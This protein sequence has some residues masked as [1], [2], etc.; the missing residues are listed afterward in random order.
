[1]SGVAMEKFFGALDAGGWKRKSVGGN[2]FMAICPAHPDEKPSLSFMEGRDGVMLYCHA[3]CHT[4]DVVAAMSL[5]MSD[6]F[7]DPRGASY[8]YTLNG[9]PVRRV[10]RTPDKVFSQ[11]VIDKTLVTLFATVPLDDLP[12]EV[13]IVEGEKDVLTLSTIGVTAVSAPSGAANW[14]LC[15]YTPLM[16]C[17]KIV[18]VADRD[19][20]G[21]KRAMGLRRLLRVITAAEVSVLISAEGKDATDHVVSGH[22]IG[23]FLP[24]DLPDDDD[25]AVDEALE[26]DIAAQRRV[27][28]VRAEAIRRDEREA[29]EHLRKPLAAKLLADIL[30]MDT[31]YHWQIPGLLEAQDRLV[32]TGS[33]GGGKSMLIRQIG[34]CAAG[35]M[36]PFSHW[37]EEFE[38]LRVLFVDAENTERQ[39]G[40]QSSYMVGRIEKMMNRELRRNVSVSAQGRLDLSV[41]SNLD[42]VH[43]LCD[44]EKPDILAIGPL[45]KLVPK[46]ITTD[47]EAAPLITALDSFRDRGLTLLMEAHA[48]HSR[49]DMRPRGS[50]AL[51]G[52]PEVGFGLKPVTDGD[53]RVMNVVRWRGD[54]DE[55]DWPGRLSRGSRDFGQLPWV[56]TNIDD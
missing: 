24:A 55:R 28:Y 42:E 46:E 40:R 14:H 52:W 32:I 44:Q 35:G 33:E 15:D 51:L 41:K 50:S 8:E 23:E 36:H 4:E 19:E 7:N 3:G 25:P 39:W 48:G 10:Y 54:R 2:R 13:W 21:M 1:M 16:A 5:T 38:P 34:L 26:Q 53:L 11:S 12:A 17:S 27:N 43:R 45:Y 6:L 30:E 49:E 37:E 20:A 18:I 47:N 9:R 31:N 56:Q 22:G 29:S